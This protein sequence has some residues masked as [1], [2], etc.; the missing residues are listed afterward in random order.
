[1]CKMCKYNKYNLHVRFRITFIL[2]ERIREKF[3]CNT[4]PALAN[5]F[6]KEPPPNGVLIEPAL[7]PLFANDEPPP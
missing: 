2:T 7:A 5:E 1:M 4:Y 6:A 3:F